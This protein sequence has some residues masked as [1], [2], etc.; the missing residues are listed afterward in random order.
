MPLVISRH[1]RPPSPPSPTDTYLSTTPVRATHMR[2]SSSSYT[3]TVT[4]G[5]QPAPKVNVTRLAIEGRARQNQDGASV[6]VYLK[7]SLPLDSV[8]PG[9]TVPLFPEENVKVLESQVHPLDSNSVP[10]HFS[11]ALSPLLHNAARA[12]NL[13]PRLPETFNSVFGITTGNVSVPSSSARSYSSETNRE[14]VTLVDPHYAGHILVSNYAIS[15][16]LPKVFLTRNRSAMD[17]EAGAQSSPRGRRASISE[18]N[19]VHF[20]AAIDMWV[21]YVSRPPRSPY[22]LSIPLPRC[23]HNHIK[24]RIFPPSPTSSSFA[25]L[26]S[27]ED[28]GSTWDLASDPHVARVVSNR[29]GRTNSYSHFADDESSDS[30]HAG[31][32]DGC[33]IQGTFP[34]AERVR[35]RWAKPMKVV[36]VPDG[37]D[38]RRR[39]GIREVRGDMTCTVQG[40]YKDPEKGVEGIVMHVEYKGACKGIW[41]PGV[42]TLLGLDVGLEAKNSDVSWVP[43][44]SGTWEVGGGV[45][46]TGFDVGRGSMLSPSSRSSSLDSGSPRMTFPPAEF[47]GSNG[48]LNAHSNISTP[49]LLRAPLPNSNIDEYLDGSGGENSTELTSSVSSAL[50]A[51][52][53]LSDAPRPPGTPITLHLNMNELLPPVQ[54]VFTFAISGT[55]LLTSRM[56]LARVNRQG[57]GKLDVN[58]QSEVDDGIEPEPIVL[59]RFTVL[60]A[61]AESTTIIVRN[62]AEGPSVVEVYNATGDLKDA[63]I[64]KT[65]LQKGGFTKCGDDGGRVVLKTIRSGITLEVP[66]RSRTPNA[67]P[68]SHVSSNSSLLRVASPMRLKRYGPLIIP[69]V[70][71]RIN[72]FSTKNNPRLSYAVRSTLNVPPE[73]ESGWLEFGL[74]LPRLRRTKTKTP[75]VSIIS[76]SIEGVPVGFEMTS[77]NTSKKTVAT[78][79]YSAFE[80]V[81]GAEWIIWARVYIGTLGGTHVVIDYLVDNESE[82]DVAKASQRDAL[83]HLLLP[84]FALPVGRLDGRISAPPDLY[85]TNF[86]TNFTV[87][88][89]GEGKCKFSHFSTTEYFMPQ[90]SLTLEPK[91]K[92]SPRLV[93]STLLHISPW[94]AFIATF[95]LLQRFTLP[96]R[97]LTQLSADLSQQNMTLTSTNEV[98]IMEP[99]TTTSTVYTTVTITSTLEPIT[100]I[101]NGKPRPSPIPNADSLGPT[102]LDMEIPKRTN[103]V[104]PVIVAAETAAVASSQLAWTLPWPIEDAHMAAAADKLWDVADKVWQVLRRAYH[105]PLDPP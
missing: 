60:A 8:T 85:I 103:P 18:R 32:S 62:E 6:K 97:E 28:D 16:L 58:A 100:R 105:Y 48:Q 10:Y 91:I 46:Y 104:N 71:N 39:V 14:S 36:D 79:V 57:P 67:H 5:G 69:A 51:S 68:P 73:T 22:L 66:A 63:Q 96:I 102:A 98:D 38:G 13:S 27:I 47:P 30:S 40:K 41:F 11:S 52:V 23:L 70:E 19:A 53:S 54:S 89:H 25:S 37:G 20:M 80:Q 87:Q 82:A 45:G 86:E 9:S 94:L 81:G 26:S 35:L 55:I 21:P 34:S 44:L 17:V 77:A 43:G 99:L 29:L 90:V 74:A 49:S 4:S 93:L 3:P 31:L 84:T 56:T 7:I 101:D 50:Q 15:Y 76:A 12:L 59:P 92:S 61:D 72:L 75:R 65:V 42:A 24:L 88:Q 83:E 33:I 1:T 95:L 2:R 64:R 78:G